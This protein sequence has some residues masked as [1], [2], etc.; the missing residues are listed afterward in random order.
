M[1]RSDP[2]YRWVPSHVKTLGPVVADLAAL[3]G[4]VPDEDQAAALDAIF[5][6]GP[7]NKAVALE[8]AIIAGRQNIKTSTFKM[9]VLGWLYVTDQRTITWSAHEF[10]AARDA[11]RELAELVT[12]TPSLSRRLKAVHHGA[13]DQSIE[14][15]TGQRVLF[16]A[17]TNTGGRGLS[18][19]KMV[20]DEAFA[21]TDTHIGALFPT[22]SPRED[23]Q[24]LYGSSAGLAQS[25]FLRSVRD[26]G[27]TGGDPRLAYI[28][29]TDD[30]PGDCSEPACDHKVTRQGCRLDDE[31]RWARAN[32]ALGRRITYDYVRA[33]RRG[34]PAA[35]FARERL[36]WWDEGGTP[37]AG[38][39]PAE[40]WDACRTSELTMTAPVTFAVEV[41]EDR[42][43]TAIA[44]AS[45][46]ADGTVQVEVGDYA[47]GVSWVL[48]RLTELTRRN[49]RSRVVVQRS[50]PA[51][52][53]APAMRDRG[54]VT[55][56]PTA[57]DYAT[58]CGALHDLVTSAGLR[59]AGQPELDVAVRH[60]QTKPA[61]D[62]WVWNRRT[63]TVDI[64]P[65][66]AVTLAAWGASQKPRA[67]RFVSF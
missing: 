25:A 63:P 56:D 39:F 52:S 50:S 16:K 6:V 41:A 5:A 30:L 46:A 22:L 27:R 61:G 18:G 34:M 51:G 33:E 23:P 35:E 1:P 44:V 7:D 48:D 31:R 21:L 65:L 38:A 32:P 3:V 53:L 45:K 8:A 17:R 2:A 14:M 13:G 62:A 42:S 20:L 40:D 24:L 11:H 49:R 19:D 64:S 58:A 12:G 15:R 60:A 47:E 37:D 54:I 59:H 67:G 57:A 9:C 26:R 10:P 29:Y 4:Y 43:W 36:G 55:L 66:V 28:E